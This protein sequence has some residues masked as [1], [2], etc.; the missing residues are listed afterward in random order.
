M[1][2]IKKMFR[3]LIQT[4]TM[5]HI[6]YKV[7]NSIQDPAAKKT[8][9]RYSFLQGK[10]A[11]ALISLWFKQL[12]II[13]VFF[14]LDFGQYHHHPDDLYHSFFIRLLLFGGQEKSGEN[15]GLNFQEE[16][17]SQFNCFQHHYLRILERCLYSASD[18]LKACTKMAHMLN[19]VTCVREMADIKK[20]RVI[21]HSA[22]AQI[23]S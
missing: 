13:F 22:C 12:L 17:F 18:R 3:P 5:N 16:V 7:F 1:E 10:V 6:D 19:A 8:E 9:E 23:S 4:H 15:S 11:D 2:T 20:S 14:S 21:N